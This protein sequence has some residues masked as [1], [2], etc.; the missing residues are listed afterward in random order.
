VTAP[1]WRCMTLAKVE[2]I[3]RE[4]LGGALEAR[5]LYN[6][7]FSFQAIAPSSSQ[8]AMVWGT[9]NPPIFSGAQ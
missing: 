1:I 9:G 5:D 7:V 6:R 4:L 2:G 3:R 8:A